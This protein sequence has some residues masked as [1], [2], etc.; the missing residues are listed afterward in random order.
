MQ[1]VGCGKLLESYI[2]HYPKVNL[3]KLKI[4]HIDSILK[5]LK[6]VIGQ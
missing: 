6:P 5:T 1:F 4:P 2:A 3:L